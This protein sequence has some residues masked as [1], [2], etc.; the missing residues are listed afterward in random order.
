MMINVVRAG[1]SDM[2]FWLCRLVTLLLLVTSASASAAQL[3]VRIF[4]RG[5]KAPLQGVAVCLGTSAR[6]TQFGTGLTNDEGYVT[7]ADVPRTRLLVTASRPGYMGEQERM[8]GSGENRMLVLSLS[9]GG[10]GVQCPLNQDVVA[11]R[12]GSLEIESFLL[13]DGAAVTE[14]TLVTLD[15]T[16]TGHATQYRASER[17][18]FDGAEWQTYEG[19]PRFRLSAGLGNKTIYFQVRR[20]TVING[21]AIESRSAIMHDTISVQ[22]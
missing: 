13:N 18:D 22:F 19:K 16:I 12:A 4:E 6:L 17:S 7:F 9:T 3:T 2:K 8:A 10:G 5:G 1:L 11:R 14:N 15:N 21:A 20:H